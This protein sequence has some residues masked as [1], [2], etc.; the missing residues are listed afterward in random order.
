MKQLIIAFLLIFVSCNNKDDRSTKREMGRKL[1]ERSFGLLKILKDKDPN[2]FVVL[3]K[4]K[5][6]MIIKNKSEFIPYYAE[7][8]CIQYPEEIP[9]IK[10]SGLHFTKVLVPKLKIEKVDLEKNEYTISFI[11]IKDLYQRVKFNK[12]TNKWDIISCNK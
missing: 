7:G 3:C 5:R 2:N 4:N 11:N 8:E 6:K 1:C 10:P 12:L 9:Y